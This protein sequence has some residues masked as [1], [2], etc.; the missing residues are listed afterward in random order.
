M[1]NVTIEVTAKAIDENRRI[2]A[3]WQGYGTGDQLLQ[4]VANSTQ[5]SLSS[6]PP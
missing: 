6:W 1:N 3:E 4:Y 2:V 5:G